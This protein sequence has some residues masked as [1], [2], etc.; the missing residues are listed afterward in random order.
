MGVQLLS[1]TQTQAFISTYAADVSGVC[2]ALY[3]LGGMCIMHDASGCNST[4]N[5]HDEPRWYDHDS[6]VFISALSELEAIMG[7]DEK[8]I[9]DIITAAE[10][11]SPRFIAIAGTPIP[12]MT[13]CDLP[14]IAADIEGRIGI[15][16]FGFKTNGMSS[17]VRGAGAALAAYAERFVEPRPRRAHSV[18]LLGATPL[19]LSVNG[20]VNSM[21]ELLRRG[22]YEVLSTWA[23]G[24][25]PEQLASA[26]EAEVNLV[27]SSVGL[28]T[29]RLL[30]RRHGTP[31]V[32]GMPYAPLGED[33]LRLL[34]VT[35][36]DGRPRAIFD[37]IA[38]RSDAET[39]I[40][41]ECV[42]SRSYAAALCRLGDAPAR[43][44]CPLEQHAGLLSAGD[45]ALGEETELAAALSGAGRVI[46][47]PLYRLIVPP[48]AEFIPL[49]HEA[50]SGRLFRRSIPDLIKNFQ[51]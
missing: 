13:G 23:M 8:L 15:P 44:I 19:D 18:N 25:T 36:S 46:A 5:T 43:V 9:R 48:T 21:V 28:E 29:A 30:H 34:E 49:P 47:D 33:I 32:I 12:M 35:A 2:S 11:L 40:I 42:M 6:L 17:Y 24:S 51:I 16:C 38:P 27:I 3:E 45:A 22:G 41:G 14:A 31:Y 4:Y 50:F 1:V 10:Q 26:A 20:A 37:N 39:V 7:D